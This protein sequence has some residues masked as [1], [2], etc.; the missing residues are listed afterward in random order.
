MRNYFTL[1]GADSRNYGVYISG[2]GTFNS[3]ART[4]NALPV[5]GRN[6][7]LI[8]METRLENGEFV[9]KDAFIYSSFASKIE[10][11]KALLMSVVGYRKLIDSYHP[12][13]YRMVIYQ[14]PLTVKPTKK[15]DAAQFDI[16]FNAKPQRFLI[17]GDTATTLTASGTISN[18]TLF[19]S[20]PLIRVYGNG[21]LGVGSDSITIINNSGNY[22]DI[23]C[24]AGLAY[25]GATNM[26]S[27]ITLSVYDFPALVGGTNNIALGT[28]ITKVE[29]TPRW[30]RV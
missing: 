11:F 4:V 29:I 6:G 5:P 19:P 10:T 25:R 26:N 23:D 15:N 3:P 7:D 22:I 24:D 18:P 1:G 14:G 21:V 13:E 12:D 20:R 9:Y 16:V 28:G 8:G 27:S 2:Q 30:W 17:S